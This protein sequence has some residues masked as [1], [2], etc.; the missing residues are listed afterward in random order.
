MKKALLVAIVIL[1]SASLAYSADFNPTLLK[2]SADPVIQY[3][4]D[5]SNIEIPVQV[6]GKDAGII[7]CVY[8]R[9]MAAQIPDM[10]NGFLGWHQVNKVDTCIYY[11][12]LNSVGI[13]N[14]TITWS[15]KDQ[16]GGTVTPGEY[17]YYL[18]AYDNM[19]AKEQ[20]TEFMRPYSSVYE[21]QEVD[22][23]G[24]P[25]AHP[26]Y[27]H[28]SQRWYVGNDAK[29]E[30]LLETTSI[31]MP[32]GWGARN[33]Q[34]IDP[35]DFNYFYIQ[36]HNN[37]ASQAGLSKW[38]WVPGGESEM[39]TDF[40][41]DGYSELFT[42]PSGDKPGVLASQDYLYTGDQNHVGSGEPDTDFYIYDYEGYMIDEIDLSPWWSSPDAFE[43]G[44]QMNGGPNELA[45][46]HEKV[47]L[48]CHCSCIK[49]M[50]DPIRY[51]ES[52]EVEDFYVWTNRNGDYV[53]DHNFED[54]ATLKW[55]CMDYNVGPYTYN[56][57]ADDELFS[58][59][60]AYD[61]GAVSFGLMGPDGTGIGYFAFSGETAGW[62]KGSFFIDSGTAY[63][64]MYCDNEHTGGPHYDW[65]A[66]L[67]GLGCYFIGHD[68]IS[69]IITNAINVAEAAPVGF[70]V[71]Q[72]APNPFNPTTTIS[73]SL[74]QAGNVDVD[75]FNVAGQKVATLA[76][77]F[78]DAGSHSVVWEASDF[79]AGV[80]FYTVK[81]G[82][83]SKTMK[84][85]LLK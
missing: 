85:T 46:R 33:I 20:M 5:G 4:F 49:Q 2:L 9:G 16:D 29:D 73:F 63:D 52:G 19:G 50:V 71:G 17:T 79:S 60:P 42:A 3:D 72:H 84:M 83:F 56:M 67:R 27:Y 59:C 22:T 28:Y 18:W 23:D 31:S 70:E 25:L 11:S 53:N 32:T 7:F 34:A 13:G 26:I 69:G 8:T 38:K 48:N 1:C 43:L 41:E 15:G 35:T 74:A 10:V 44:A 21:M 37:D 57:A 62:K 55:I 47:F 54:T 36:I 76:D 45:I 61:V 75:V 64:G 39:Q 40:G 51:L 78:M 14:T 24:L 58:E 68:S 6:S 12:T 80:Y 77:G 66:D 81:S 82:S 30:A 65:N